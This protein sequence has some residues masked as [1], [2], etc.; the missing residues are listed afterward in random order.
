[1]KIATFNIGDVAHEFPLLLDWLRQAGPD[2]LCL[3]T[4]Q[5]T[6]VPFP[7]KP[8]A[9]LG[10]GAAWSGPR[11]DHRVAI[12]AKSTV[13][14]PI[15]TSLPGSPQD[16]RGGYVEAAVHGML[17]ASLRS[18]TGGPRPDPAFDDRLR[19]L[20]RLNAHAAELIGQGMPVV[21]AGD[22]DVAPTDLDSH[23][24]QPARN[25]VIQPECRRAFRWL[26]RQ[27]W[28]DAIRERHPARPHYTFWD[29]TEDWERD[30]GLRLD[31]ILV[32][33]LLRKHLIDAGTDRHIRRH[34][35]TGGHAPVWIEIQ[36]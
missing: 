14:I 17:V 21:L 12:L 25:A 2:I 6:H 26:I 10:Y 29:G 23:A 27:G 16:M 35:G 32:S 11:A 1:M 22:F 4:S 33:P 30:A 19:W 18:P 15:Q 5:P 34:L 24:T 28:T 20:E 3:Q 8:L 13:P 7:E 31:H 36:T 9:A